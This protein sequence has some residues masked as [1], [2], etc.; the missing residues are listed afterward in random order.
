V[1][2]TEFK[3]AI[4]PR[5]RR[6]A[7][8]AV[9]LAIS[10][11]GSPPLI[12]HS[13]TLPFPLS[14]L[15]PVHALADDGDSSELAGKALQAYEAA[16]AATGRRERLEGFR[17]AE[18]LFAATVEAGAHNAALYT[19]LG[20]AALSAEHLGRAVLA[21]RRA[22]ALDPDNHKALANL[23]HARS[24]LPAW[25]PRPAE[26]GILDT[27]FFWEGSLTDG[28]RSRIG[29]VAFL[30]ASALVAV[31][32]FWNL[33]LARLAALL[34]L[35]VWAALGL[36]ARWVDDS[37]HNSAVLVS[38]ETVAKSSDSIHAASRFSEPLPGGTE[39]HIIEK[40]RDWYQ[41]RIGKDAQAWVP[42]GGVEP[43]QPIEPTD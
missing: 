12:Q 43:I 41:V 23:T 32:A 13:P 35:L 10:W 26:Q 29:A 40:R 25:V 37:R 21:Y 6:L 33:P 1:R 39:V 34:P 42:T 16:Q 2:R 20:N 14:A 31:A 11:F 4:R 3:T 8:F 22:L 15:A 9:L 24:L 27:F 36:S 7:V 30:L 28:E 19:N 5:A 18:G 17:R 38:A